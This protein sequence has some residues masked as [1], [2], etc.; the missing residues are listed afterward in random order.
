MELAEAH[1][2]LSC[3]VAGGHRVAEHVRTV[4]NGRVGARGRVAVEEH[5]ALAPINAVRAG[6]PRPP[7][8]DG[9]GEGRVVEVRLERERARVL[10]ADRRAGREGDVLS[11]AITEAEV[12]DLRR[13]LGCG[14]RDGRNVQVEIVERRDAV[15]RRRHGE[16]RRAVH[17]DAVGHDLVD[18][19]GEGVEV[20]LPDVVRVGNAA[21]RQHVVVGVG[22]FAW[23]EGPCVVHP[24]LG[25][26]ATGDAGRARRIRRNLV[27]RRH[28]HV[29]T[30]EVPGIN[31]VDAKFVLPDLLRCV[32]HGR[33]SALQWCRH[34]IVARKCR[35]LR[36]GRDD[37]HPIGIDQLERD[38]L[39]VRLAAGGHVDHFADGQDVH[40]QRRGTGVH[41]A[42][43]QKVAERLVETD[44][45]DALGGHAGGKQARS[46]EQK[47]T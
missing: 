43:A 13:R 6:A 40:G 15:P 45:E 41:A 20:E 11:I 5:V 32:L 19:A 29:K 30:V 7:R 33:A 36:D 31:I 8:V 42:D 3:E 27:I 22:R 12:R 37:L 9:D 38:L 4:P 2:D 17:A 1:G 28:G 23:V 24:T 25:R 39:R 14:L 21:R 26:D 44:L 10:H 18:E 16:G 34:R 46:R 47:R 35:C